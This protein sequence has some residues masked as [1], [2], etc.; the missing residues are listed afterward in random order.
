MKKIIRKMTAVLSAAVTVCAAFPVSAAKIPVSEEMY[1]A[2]RSDRVNIVAAK[3]RD[4]EWSDLKYGI[5]Q[6]N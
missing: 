4:V 1:P 3:Y 6:S 2:L 5:L